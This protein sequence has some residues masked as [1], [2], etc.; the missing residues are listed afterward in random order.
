MQTAPLGHLL[1]QAGEE[2][3][4]LSPLKPLSWANSL[5][6]HLAVRPFFLYVAQTTLIFPYPIR[7]MTAVT[8]I[9]P[10]NTRQS[11]PNMLYLLLI[12]II[13]SGID[14]HNNAFIA[15]R[16]RRFFSRWQSHFKFVLW[17]NLNAKAHQSFLEFCVLC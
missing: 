4:P 1:P 12:A 8:G 7:K 11:D 17:Q 6:T 13:L 3:S 2:E 16:K 9:T 10:V 15:A 5:E 14:F